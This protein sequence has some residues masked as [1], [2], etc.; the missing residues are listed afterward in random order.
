LD[1][2]LTNYAQLSHAPFLVYVQQ[3]EKDGILD[4]MEI[5]LS[6]AIEQDEEEKTVRQIF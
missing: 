1:A 6:M 2:I 5:R 3:N 4:K